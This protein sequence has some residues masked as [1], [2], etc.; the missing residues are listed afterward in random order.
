MIQRP[1]GPKCAAAEERCQQ[2]EYDEK[3]SGHV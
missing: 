1:I 2:T 3:S